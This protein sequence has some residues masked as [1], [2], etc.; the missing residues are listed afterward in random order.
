[1][2]PAAAK[3]DYVLILNCYL[4]SVQWKGNI[5]DAV[6]QYLSKELGM[7]VHTEHVRALD[8]KT[9][10]Q[11]REKLDSLYQKYPNRPEA[12][13][14][15]GVAAWELFAEG[16]ETRWKNI[17][18]INCSIRKNTISLDN[19]L[20]QREVT[21]EEMIPVDLKELQRK[22]NMTGIAVPLNIEGT[23]DLMTRTQTGMN[24]IVFISDDRMGSAMARAQLKRVMIEKYKGITV[25]YFSPSKTSTNQLLNKLGEYDNRTGILFY[26]WYSDGSGAEELY[27]S[28]NIYKILSGF[29]NAP[30]FSLMD[31]GMEEGYIAGGNFNDLTSQS[32]AVIGILK[33]VLKGKEPRTIPVKTLNNQRNHLNYKALSTCHINN[34]AFPDDAIYYDRPESFL[35]K[36]RYYIAGVAMTLLFILAYLLL[37]VRMLRKEKKSKER[38]LEREKALQKEISIR[39]YKLAMTLEVSTIRPW[40]WHLNENV[41]YFDDV[42]K[43]IDDSCSSDTTY[44]Q[45]AEDFFNAITDDTRGRIAEVISAIRNGKVNY[46]REDFKRSGPEDD[47][48]CE[49]YTLQCVVFERDKY[50]KPQTLIGAMMLIT[51][52]KRLE[53]ELREAKKKAEESNQLKSAFLANMSHEIRTPL[54]AIVGFS[55]LIAASND[56]KEKKELVDIVNYNNKLLLRLINNIVELS[57]MESNSVIFEYRPMDVNAMIDY[58]IK[59]YQADVKPAVSVVKELPVP[60]CCINSSKSRLMQALSNYMSNATKFTERGS[61]TIGYYPPENG[62]IRFFVKDTGCG[63]PQVQLRTVF[64]RFVKLNSFAQGTGL[65]LSV[66][67][68]IAEKMG[69][70]CGAFSKD[71]EGS[72]FWIEV[73]YE[74]ASIQTGSEERHV[75]HEIEDTS[76]RQ[77]TILVAE[78][79]E[80]N[81]AIVNA[82]LGKK[83]HIIH[84]NNGLEAVRLFREHSPSLVLMDVRMPVLDGYAATA[85]IR[86][87][88]A[89]VPIIAVTAFSFDDDKARMLHNGFNAYK[90]KPLE[91]KDLEDSIINMLRNC[92]GSK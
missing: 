64:G 54:N 68:M 35:Q 5:E 78:D 46:V 20:N 33:Q 87:Y 23:I 84:A 21:K 3:E 14:Y 88:N 16:I 2:L 67:Q 36:Y 42:K 77:T 58:I 66:V 40:V 71:N 26:T 70:T 74:V 38:E 4:E 81:F 85:E 10:Q 28:N 90:S 15:I 13:I 82:M 69:G 61:I 62:M 73:P 32:E 37:Y 65:G 80:D 8:I 48:L 7:T 44:S 60:G 50:G 89:E 51:E 25:E 53:L 34:I 11:Q 39:N 55:G 1:M 45:S 57:K 30:V 9:K 83:Y 19:L 52:S 79:D 86:K 76:K 12:V 72:E 59:E 18:M 41:I 47:G 27:M 6:T 91:K 17:P 49:W 29:T 43:I 22:Y 31:C 75:D 92:H 24:H 56:E 63:I